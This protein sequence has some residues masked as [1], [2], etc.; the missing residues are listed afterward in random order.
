MSGAAWAPAALCAALGLLLGSLP[1]RAGWG[2]AAALASALFAV[3]GLGAF[4]AASLP[5]F[6]ASAYSTAACWIGTALA[7]AALHL[8]AAAR[9]RVAPALA[10]L[11]GALAAGPA[12]VATPAWAPACVLLALPAH[13][14]AAR[15]ATVAVKV[16]GSW[17]LAVALLALA[18]SAQPALPGDL[19]DHLE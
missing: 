8:P 14:L 7:G 10:G 11:A 5:P 9:V 6:V 18:L 4:F 12:S 15:D 13:A 1:R 16:A 19:P 17:L 2:S 3:A